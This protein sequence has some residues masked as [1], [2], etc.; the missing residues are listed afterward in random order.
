MIHTQVYIAYITFTQLL[1]LHLY[2]LQVQPW[3]I[4][5]CII[6]KNKKQN[7]N[8]KKN[9]NKRKEKQNKTKTYN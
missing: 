7:K 5:R 8:K 6:I 1:D 3:S 9:K 2:I 4:S